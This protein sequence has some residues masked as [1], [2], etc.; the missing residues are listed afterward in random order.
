MGK[1]ITGKA[2]HQDLETFLE[3]RVQLVRW[4]ADAGMLDGLPALADAKLQ[5]PA[6][7]P[8][9]HG[10]FLEQPERK[11]ER[12]EI[13]QRAES[14]ASWY[15]GRGAARNSPRRGRH[16][17]LR[18]MMLGEMVAMEA[19]RLV[20]LGERQPMGIMRLYAH[21]IGVDMIEDAEFHGRPSPVLSAIL[22]RGGTARQSHGREA[23]QR[24]HPGDPG[25]H[26]G[27][28]WRSKPPSSA[29]WV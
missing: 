16:A 11:V 22:E 13:D 1:P 3:A 5:P 15:A 19:Q 24:L 29:T 28:P 14:A 25:P 23:G 26:G 4:H 8:V 27:K 21:A 10:D 12:Q 7:H 18:R 20:A 2:L 17:E 9:E 6:T